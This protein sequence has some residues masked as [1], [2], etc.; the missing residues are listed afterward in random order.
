MT[1]LNKP[2]KKSDFLFF[3]C[4]NLKRRLASIL[5]NGKSVFESNVV[6]ALSREKKKKTLIP[7]RDIFK[8]FLSAGEKKH[9]IMSV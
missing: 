5:F 4:S 1:L 7:S 8:R 3:D 9:V 2:R 6:W